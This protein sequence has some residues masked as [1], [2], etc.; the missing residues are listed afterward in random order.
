MWGS[1]TSTSARAWASAHKYGN[2]GRVKT[3]LE[4]PDPLFRK[5]KA[6]AAEH[7]QTVKAFVTE[8]LREKLMLDRGSRSRPEP[9]W[10]KGFSKLKRLHKE[11][12]RVQSVLD[13]EFGL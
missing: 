2:M 10:M 1:G 5:A 4:L 6:T 13:Q 8:A 9:E 7:G 11:I 12:V 3:T